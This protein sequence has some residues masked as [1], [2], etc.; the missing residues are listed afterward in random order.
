MAWFHNVIQ[1]PNEDTVSADCSGRFCT[2]Y[3]QLPGL[4]DE[5]VPKM[6][7]NEW[8]GCA[9][10]SLKDFPS[11]PHHTSPGPPR[12]ENLSCSSSAG[13]Q[14]KEPLPI[15]YVSLQEQRCVLSWFQAWS[16]DQ[17]E[18]F[19]QD[20]LGKA[21]PGKVCTLLDSLSTLQ[22]VAF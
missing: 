2:A 10:S 22:V 15:S 16:A 13:P 4:A 18:R 8:P 3:N 6:T 9:A 20:L 21:V 5:T 1:G 17:R 12:L 7:P 11:V 19:M 14:D